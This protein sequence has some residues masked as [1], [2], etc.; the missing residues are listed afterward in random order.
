MLRALRAQRGSGSHHGRVG[1]A[2]GAYQAASKGSRDIGYRINWFIRS[3]LISG[4]HP[5]DPCWDLFLYRNSAL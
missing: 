4:F 3:S 5:R 2:Q 1:S